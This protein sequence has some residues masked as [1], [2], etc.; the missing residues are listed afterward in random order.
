M[1]HIFVSSVE[2]FVQ[3]ATTEVK[4]MTHFRV[5]VSFIGRNL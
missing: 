4:R 5:S 3:L 1:L 2:Y